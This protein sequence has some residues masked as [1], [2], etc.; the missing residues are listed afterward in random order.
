MFPKVPGRMGLITT[1]ALISFNVYNSVEAPQPR[2]FSFIEIWMIGTQI[3][4]LLAVCEYGFVLFLK[5][6]LEKADDQIQSIG[7]EDSA[8]RLDGRIK[9][10]D[11]A[12]M[13]F[14]F[15]Y[16]IILSTFYYIF[17]PMQ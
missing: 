3:P 8:S 9:K 2:G 14:S 12:T 17:A 10:L 5:K 16:I 11:F 6:T 4:I 7:V 15:L 1:L 13:I